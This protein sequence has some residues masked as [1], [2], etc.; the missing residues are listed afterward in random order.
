MSN[1]TV[2]INRLQTL[3]VALQFPAQ[4]AFDQMLV[5]RDGVNDVVQ[6]LRSEVLRTQIRIVIGL[7]Q[8][9]L[10]RRRTT[11]VNV[12]TGYL[13]PLFGAHFNPE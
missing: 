13:A 1:A 2:A 10:E 12:V 8:H 7:L 6:L 4:I 3:Q 5:V 11:A 9:A